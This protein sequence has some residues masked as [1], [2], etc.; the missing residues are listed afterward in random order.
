MDF[1]KDHEQLTDAVAT[2][3]RR[4]FARHN[5]TT[6]LAMFDAVSAASNDCRLSHNRET[7]NL[8]ECGRKQADTIDRIDQA[9]NESRDAE[10]RTQRELAA[11]R[12]RIKELE[13]RA[14]VQRSRIE[15]LLHLSV[16]QGRTI[17][18]L[19]VW[20]PADA[21]PASSCACAC[22]ALRK[23][24]EHERFLRTSAQHT[25]A[26]LEADRKD[27]AKTIRAL[28]AGKRRE[29]MRRM[30]AERFAE[31]LIH[32]RVGGPAVEIVVT[33]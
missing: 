12:D 23:E 33:S 20:A 7:K 31:D 2:L 19:S 8:E 21:P 4:L 25:V 17:K 13:Q 30:A 18:S 11:S 26:L 9:F 22:S 3:G 29:G 16:E 32:E 6:T 1:T 24:V 27:T 28:L 15:E 5:E 14:T 10:T